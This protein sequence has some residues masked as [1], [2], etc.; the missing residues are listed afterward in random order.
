[1]HPS[2]VISVKDDLLLQALGQ[3][4]K[5]CRLEQR[6]GTVDLASRARISRN[7][8]RCIERGDPSTAIGTYL[9]VMSVLGVGVTFHLKAAAAA[10]DESSASDNISHA[11]PVAAKRSGH[12]LQDIQSLALH[13]E[14]VRRVKN[15]PALVNQAMDVL[16]RWLATSTPRTAPLWLE[17]QHILETRAWRKVLASTDRAQQLRQASPLLTILEPPTRQAILTQVADLRRIAD[18]K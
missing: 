12:H 2:D 17:W 1:M 5:Q 11:M 9:R 6:I 18:R 4:L 15:N 3:Q 13:R 16:A 7:T 10:A 14:A 8:L